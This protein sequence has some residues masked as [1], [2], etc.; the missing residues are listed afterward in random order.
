M[1]SRRGE[2]CREV[3]AESTNL[4]AEAEDSVGS[5]P[6]NSRG[7]SAEEGISF[8]RWEMLSCEECRL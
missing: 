6:S 3:E 7:A 8:W 2:L 4:S 5:G 1:L